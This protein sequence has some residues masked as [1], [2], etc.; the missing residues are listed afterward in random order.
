MI[1]IQADTLRRDHLDVYG[2]GRETA[3]GLRK[4]AGEGTRFTNYTTQATW[5]TAAGQPS[6]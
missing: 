5:T 3:P 1:L 2:Y 4:L 6:S